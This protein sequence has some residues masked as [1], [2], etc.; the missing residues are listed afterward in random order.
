[1]NTSIVRFI[2]QAQD[3]DIPKA[4]PPS[5]SSNENP[6]RQRLKEVRELPYSTLEERDKKRFE[7]MKLRMDSQ[8]A[9]AKIWNDIIGAIEENPIITEGE[10]IEQVST[11]PSMNVSREQLSSFASSLA[12]QKQE[13]MEAYD[14][15]LPLTQDHYNEVAGNMFYSLYSGI[16]NPR[17]PV[18][19]LK[20]PLAITLVVSKEDFEKVDTRTNVGGFYNCSKEILVH[21]QKT[22]KME[23]VSLPFIF[24]KAGS[25]VV[26]TRRQERGHVEKRGLSTVATRRHEKGHAENRMF[27]E[28]TIANKGNVKNGVLRPDSR[29]GTTLLVSESK[30]YWGVD[31]DRMLL[32]E[33]LG[34]IGTHSDWYY[35]NS[36][37]LSPDNA[38]VKIFEGA[39]DTLIT[40]SMARAKDELIAAMHTGGPFS[41]EKM[42]ADLKKPKG[43]YDYLA[44]L[45]ISPGSRLYSDLTKRYHTELDKESKHAL[46]L[47]KWY[48]SDISLGNP[49]PKQLERCALFI[50][51]L[52]QNPI[53]TWN[54]V[55]G[56]QRTWNEA[57]DPKTKKR[58][59]KN[60]VGG[61]MLEKEG[62]QKILSSLTEIEDN[63]TK[64]TFVSRNLSSLG[65]AEVTSRIQELK[66]KFIADFSSS[67]LVNRLDVIK[68]YQNKVTSLMSQ[69]EKIEIYRA[70]V[71]VQGFLK[72]WVAIRNRLI[73]LPPSEDIDF[74]IDSQH[75]YGLELDIRNLGKK[76]SI[77]ALESAVTKGT[78]KMEDL[79]I[80]LKLGT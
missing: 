12:L 18:F 67:P 63:C 44:N 58:T 2:P 27:K 17:H 34:I 36:G 74:F 72:A 32:S 68:N 8:L 9:N 77:Q 40:Y 78:A 26:K 29:I 62:A 33:P 60:E 48:Q 10:L 55:L 53:T 46:Q 57:R 59:W 5:D 7:A 11:L 65:V 73:D 42:L 75:F 3:A 23:S 69:A 71:M 6:L 30:K 37:Y 35:R 49:I 1:M 39:R 19:L 56:P 4:L 22:E 16:P 15:Y 13:V 66:D 25:S 21:N 28:A 43:V 79:R 45:G 76:E 24:V 14:K 54:G 50:T 52:R 61:F 31:A 51:I 41:A 64:F 20:S 80:K 47:Y 38:D 70:N